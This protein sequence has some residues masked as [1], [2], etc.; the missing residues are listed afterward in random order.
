[1][2]QQIPTFNYFLSHTSTIS[3]IIILLSYNY[4]YENK[5]ST[6]VDEVVQINNDSNILFNVTEEHKNG[7][8]DTHMENNDASYIYSEGQTSEEGL[9]T[10][11]SKTS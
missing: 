11:S 4:R 2:K 8:E 6:E 5:S 7:D 3:S 1:L 10:P 9:S